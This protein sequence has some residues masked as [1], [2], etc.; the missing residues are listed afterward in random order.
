MWI[1]NNNQIK[2]LLKPFCFGIRPTLHC[3]K[4]EKTENFVA[5]FIIDSV[6]HTLR[7]NAYIVG[8]IPLPVELVN[9]ST[10]HYHSV[11]L[12]NNIIIVF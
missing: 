5:L 11:L 8:L 4:I 3:L 7:D 2:C 12:L 9:W 1:L 10:G 6:E